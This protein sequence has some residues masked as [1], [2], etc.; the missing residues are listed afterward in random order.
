MKPDSIPWVP[1]QQVFEQLQGSLEEFSKLL[2]QEESVMKRLN[3]EKM[4]VLVEHKATVL[5]KIQRSEQQL[6]AVLRP[7]VS[8][9][10]SVDCWNAITQDPRF[11]RVFQLPV[12]KAIQREITRIREQ[13]Q[14][15]SVLV[16]R[17]QY[18]V[19]EALNLVYAGLGQGPVYQGTGTL[20]VQPAPCSVNLRG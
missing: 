14:K 17:G 9:E 8:T 13:G 16:R 18:V 19:R 12:F 1:L 6:V 20:R 3:R 2:V 15:N 4:M 11:S 5:E 7:W 10:S